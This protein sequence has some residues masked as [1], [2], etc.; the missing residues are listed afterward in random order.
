MTAGM[1]PTAY[2]SDGSPRISLACN[3]LNALYSSY[4]AFLIMI[5]LS[6]FE[7]FTDYKHLLT[8]DFYRRQLIG[9]KSRTIYR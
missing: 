4:Y 1:V 7:H 9:T 5:D 8:I 2:A 6:I 3:L